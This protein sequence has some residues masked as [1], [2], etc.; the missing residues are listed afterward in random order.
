MLTA[1]TWTAS[2]IRRILNDAFAT[3]LGDE[4]RKTAVA[5]GIGRAIGYGLDLPTSPVG[6]VR[7]YYLSTFDRQACDIISAVNE[8]YLLDVQLTRSIAMRYYEMRYALV[9]QPEVLD[10]HFTLLNPLLTDYLPERVQILLDREG[11]N[12]PG[13]SWKTLMAET[14]LIVRNTSGETV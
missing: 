10:E 2:S 3:S 13:Q 9:Y 11:G 12:V 1:P 7:G 6:D 5:L 14:G 4:N 8:Q